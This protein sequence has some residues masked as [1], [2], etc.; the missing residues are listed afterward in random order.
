[1]RE[2]EVLNLSG[3]AWVPLPRL[4]RTIPYGYK[5]SDNDPE[6][7][8]PIIFELEALERAKEYR[9]KKHSYQKLAVWLSQVTGRSITAEGLRKRLEIDSQRRR[10]AQTLANWARKYKEALE[11][12]KALDER[13]G[14]DTTV[15]RQALNEL[16]QISTHND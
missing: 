4:G 16:I 9:A 1:M 3:K 8:E 10:K 11:A 7:L 5:V 13:L 12:A 2:E 14:N 15:Y 6:V